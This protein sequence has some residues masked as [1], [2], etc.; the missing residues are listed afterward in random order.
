M[1]ALQLGNK[2]QH[3]YNES[4]YRCT[5]IFF[6]KKKRMVTGDNIISAITTAKECGILP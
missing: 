1:Q 6:F 5:I 3:F 4:M 2:Y